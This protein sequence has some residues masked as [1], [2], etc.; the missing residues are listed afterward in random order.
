ME[1]KSFKSS[2]LSYKW[3]VMI[4]V[5]IGTFMSTLDSSIVNVSLP[6]IMSDFSSTIND[7]EWVMTGYMLA[8]AVLMPLT[9]WIRERIGYKNLFLM[10]LFIFT[11]GSL[12]CG[13]AWNLPS[14]IA[15]RVIQ[16]L[17]GGAIAPTGMAMI[18]EI[19]PLKER[20]QALGV[21]GMGVIIGPAIGPTL[22]G[23]LTNLF[24]WRSIFLV[25]LPIGIIC[26]L[27]AVKMLIS[28]SQQHSS[29]HPL[30][31]WG[32]IFL[33][34]FLVSLLLGIS[35]GEDKGWTS[36]Y[37]LI[38]T[39]VA[40]LGFIGFILVE[41]NN[42]NRI[43]DI[44]LFKYPVFSTCLLTNVVRS[45]ALFGSTFLIPLFLQRIV[46]YNELQ[47]GLILLPSSLFLAILFPIAGRM[48]DKIGPKIPVI[49]GLFVLALYMFMYRNIDLN[50]DLF[51]IIFPTMIRSIGLVLLMAPVTTAMMNSIPQKK[52]GMASSMMNI[53]Q[54]VGGAIGI[55][56]F[57]TIQLNRS[58]FHLS[59]VG[60]GKFS[61]SVI[62][63]T[64][65]NLAEFAHS[66]GYN[67]KESALISKVV[68]VKTMSVS[69]V[70][71]SF[72]DAFV[73]GS[74]I[75]LFALPFA[76]L[77]PFKVTHHKSADEKGRVETMREAAF[78]D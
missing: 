59:V 38:C 47:S 10:C 35:E 73:I 50:T 32:F 34:T 26:F 18:T 21:W 29:K 22:G 55:A 1:I 17:G 33:T 75:I 36:A 66:L 56:I 58:H 16:A 72:Q 42:S 15:A 61:T 64:M 2:F 62:L 44:A 40:V 76:F 69:A 19:F 14:L 6:A 37:I 31:Y 78:M 41:I 8:F 23:Y 28:D 12:L 24:G 4:I 30:D 70:V 46:G 20:G 51:G 52:A 53:F 11:T 68:L 13:L 54:Q 43:I 60:S 45:I 25:N 7:I 48:S 27:A 5:M 9:A 67:F 74:L 71:M 39:L 77:L 57:G 65:Q 49:I 3:Q 63:K